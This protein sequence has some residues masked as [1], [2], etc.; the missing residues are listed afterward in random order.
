[1]ITEN[2][3]QNRDFNWIDVQD[4]HSEDFERITKE[5]NLPYLLV[6]D[7]LRPE[8]L[9]K[10][11]EVEE[12]HFLMMRCYDPDSSQDA[13]TI[14]DLTRKVALFMSADKI[15]SIHRVK[16]EILNKVKEKSQDVNFP[17]TSQGLVHQLCLSVIRS[18][19]KPIEE[20]QDS[21]E[22]FE[23]D[24]LARKVEMLKTTRIYV[25]RRKLFLFKRILKQTNDSLYRSRDYW[26]DNSSLL[27]D[28]RENVDQLYFQLDEV[29]DNFEHLFQLY[30][31]MQDQ[32]ANQV[33]KILTVFSSVLLPL[34]FI[35]SFY[36]MNFDALPG[37]HSSHFLHVLV[38]VM[39]MMSLLAVLYFKRKG[40]F[41][42]PN[43]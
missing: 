26:G 2:I 35:A 31:S 33:M 3:C 43:E 8:H 39:V 5:F 28:L 25:F 17:K 6:Q 21:Y 36:G 18:Y 37:L 7:T 38:L 1:M 11:E 20:L 42:V 29:S 15:I 23:T 12:N 9:P 4:P 24:I 27:Q 32:R 34:N 22:D 14:Q 40:W 16:L 41:S 10:Y 19:Q 13:I 30:I